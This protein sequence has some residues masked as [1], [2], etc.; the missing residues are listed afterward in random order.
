MEY[1]L[2]T[3]VYLKNA[4]QFS[5]TQNEMSLCVY[6]VNQVYPWNELKYQCWFPLYLLKTQSPDSTFL[7]RCLYQFI[8][9]LTLKS[10]LEKISGADD[11]C[12]QI[13]RHRYHFLDDLRQS[14]CSSAHLLS[15]TPL[16]YFAT[17]VQ[18]YFWEGKSFSGMIYC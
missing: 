17:V 14:S 10:I 8:K 16:C 6:Y 9:K 18:L 15:S 1:S 3:K 13:R 12:Y 4:F 7:T 11:A 5:P 2:V